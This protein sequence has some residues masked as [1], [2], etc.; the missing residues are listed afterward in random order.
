MNINVS[1]MLYTDIHPSFLFYDVL[2]TLLQLT[3]KALLPDRNFKKQENRLVIREISYFCDQHLPFSLFSFNAMSTVNG[4]TGLIFKNKTNAP[5]CQFWPI[6]I[7][8]NLL[9]MRAEKH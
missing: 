3:R 1:V 4:E 7:T 2:R 5:I 6:T 8:D 9:T